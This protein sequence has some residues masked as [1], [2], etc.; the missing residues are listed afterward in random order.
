MKE[1]ERKVIRFEQLQHK[2]GAVSR[3]SLARW[4]K[5]GTFPR[6]INLGENIIGWDLASVEE[7]LEKKIFNGQDEKR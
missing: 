6:R 4:E 3:S 1:K 2:L 5:A 7:W